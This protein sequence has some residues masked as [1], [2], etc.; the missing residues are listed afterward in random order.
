[1]EDEVPWY[2]GGDCDLSYVAAEAD[3]GEIRN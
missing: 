2:F 3:L 1:M